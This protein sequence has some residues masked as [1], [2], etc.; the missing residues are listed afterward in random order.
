[1]VKL[2][3]QELPSESQRTTQCNFYHIHCWQFYSPNAQVKIPE[4]KKFTTDRRE[5]P[6]LFR[7]EADIDPSSL[8]L[9]LD[10]FSGVSKTILNLLVL[11]ELEQCKFRAVFDLGWNFFEKQESVS[12]QNGKAGGY[13]FLVA[14]DFVRTGIVRRAPACLDNQMNIDLQENKLWHMNSHQPLGVSR[15]EIWNRHKRSKR[16]S[17]SEE[18]LGKVDLSPSAD[19]Q[20]ASHLYRGPK[21]NTRHALL[22]WNN[23]T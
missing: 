20:H 17:D 8:Q 4:I 21:I 13:T 2:L 10:F 9:L 22:P 3:L 11:S 6:L 5:N 7:F 16:K 1:M 19:A 15:W 23:I 18:W 14:K 12:R